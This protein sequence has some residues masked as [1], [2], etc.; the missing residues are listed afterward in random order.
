M[1]SLRRN[2]DMATPSTVNLFH[3]LEK[4]DGEN[5]F[6]VEVS[7]MLSDQNQGVSFQKTR[8]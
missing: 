8:Y 4:K 2:T 7:F 3:V 6:H 1:V 5:K